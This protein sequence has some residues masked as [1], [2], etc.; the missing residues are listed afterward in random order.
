MLVV[1]CVVQFVRPGVVG[2]MALKVKVMF[3]PVGITPPPSVA[4]ML[5]DVAVRV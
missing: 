1:A 4:L 3:S 5:I 2:A